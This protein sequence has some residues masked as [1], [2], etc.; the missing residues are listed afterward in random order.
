VSTDLGNPSQYP[1]AFRNLFKKQ[2]VDVYYQKAANHIP[3]RYETFLPLIAKGIKPGGFLVTS[4]FDVCGNLNPPERCIEDFQL[5]GD[6]HEIQ[7]Y[8]RLFEGTLLKG[9]KLSDPHNAMQ[10]GYKPNGREY[11]LFT[12][13]RQKKNS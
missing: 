5:L 2:K 10:A 1:K 4:D 6:T 12:N 7:S 8:M 13:R 11:W 9:W 3:A